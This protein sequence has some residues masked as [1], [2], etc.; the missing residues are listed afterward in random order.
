MSIDPF[1]EFAPTTEDRKF[2]ALFGCSAVVAMAL[3]TLLLKHS[4]LPDGGTMTHFLWALIW[5]KVYAMEDEMKQLCGG[6]DQKTIR[7]WV[8]LFVP[9][10]ASLNGFVVSRSFSFGLF[11]TEKEFWL[12]DFFVL[13]CR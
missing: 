2:C 10:I 8:H 7:K 4:V 5:L 6:A 1:Q 11:I 12:I 13:T 9:A 3:W